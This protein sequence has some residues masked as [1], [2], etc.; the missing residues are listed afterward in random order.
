MVPA[1]SRGASVWPAARQLPASPFRAPAAEPTPLQSPAASSGSERVKQSCGHS[2]GNLQVMNARKRRC[3]RRPG[4]LPHGRDVWDGR[5]NKHAGTSNNIS[6]ALEMQT[7]CGWT[8]MQPNVPQMTPSVVK[9][10]CG[11]ER[12]KN[13]GPGGADCHQFGQQTGCSLSECLHA[14]PSLASSGGSGLGAGGGTRL[15]SGGDSLAAGGAGSA[16][17]ASSAGGACTSAGGACTSAGG[18]RSAG[19]ACT[20]T[21]RGTCTC[22]GARTSASLAQG[23]GGHQHLRTREDKTREWVSWWCKR[24]HA[25][26]TAAYLTRCLPFMLLAGAARKCATKPGALHRLAPLHPP[27][28]PTWSITWMMAWQALMSAWTTLAR[29]APGAE[30]TKATEEPLLATVM[31]WASFSVGSFWPAGVGRGAGREGS[32]GRLVG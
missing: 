28:P 27:H 26:S 16:G 31:V 1:A 29:G 23:I 4:R 22:G 2:P 8:P 24:V 17:G 30:G 14:R 5:V 20:S 13:G 21:G 6:H 12:I 18:A 7:Q 19:G 15:A 11:N 32:S 25:R 10:Q 3:T 9:P